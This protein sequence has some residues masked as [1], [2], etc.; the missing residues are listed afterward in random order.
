MLPSSWVSIS[1]TVLFAALSLTVVLTP[2]AMAKVDHEALL[3][4]RLSEVRE[5]LDRRQAHRQMLEARIEALS[6]ELDELQLERKAALADLSEQ[7][8]RTRGYDVELDRLMPRL[9]PRLK[10]LDSLRRQGARAIADLARLGRDARVE[11]KTKA[12]FMATR[13]VTIDQMRRASTSV[14]LL[15]RVPN[16][17]LGRHRDL[18]FQIPL[19]KSAVD[20]ASSRRDKLQRRRDS[21]I[22]DM[23]DLNGELE[24]LT[25]EEHRLARNML[26]RTLTA[27]TASSGDLTAMARTRLDRRH[28]GKTDIGR[29]QIRSAGIP[30]TSPR[31]AATPLDGVM[32]QASPSATSMA[33]SMPGESLTGKAAAEAAAAADQRVIEATIDRSARRQAQHLA[34]LQ[35]APFDSLSSR[36]ALGQ[37]EESEPLVPTGETIGYS[38]ADVMRRA[39]HPAI[40]IAAKPRQRVAAPEDG[41]VVFANRFRSYGL[42]LIIEHDSEYHT[43][44]WGFSSLDIELGDHIQAGQIVGTA[45]TGQSPKLHVELRRNG[46]PVSPELWLAASNSGVKG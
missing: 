16:D 30:R 15:R 9:L 17:L 21:A 31:L 34:A 12:R 28:T 5:L 40:E 46:E 41:V 23:A 18:D 33:P 27:G 19:L 14:R 24:R 11:A 45:G 25:T 44:L 6:L 36:V 10:R 38:L 8:D 2:P 29:A 22:R 7:V 42:L 32:N 4:D 3:R 26:A 39:D 13:S 20:R 1:A 43:L 37:L 35:A